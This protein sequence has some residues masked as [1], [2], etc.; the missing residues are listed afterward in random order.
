M[1]LAAATAAATAAARYSGRHAVHPLFAGTAQMVASTCTGRLTP[2]WVSRAQSLMQTWE[3]VAMCMPKYAEFLKK[4][5]RKDIKRAHV[6]MNDDAQ[7]R[8]GE[9]YLCCALRLRQEEVEAAG[10]DSA[11]LLALAE[12]V[13]NEDVEPFF[14][15]CREFVAS[16]DAALHKRLDETTIWREV[17]DSLFWHH[18]FMASVP[19]SYE[20]FQAAA[21]PPRDSWPAADDASGVDAILQVCA[22]ACEEG[23][24]ARSLAEETYQGF[25]D[26]S[27][28]PVQATFRGALIEHGIIVDDF[29]YEV[30]AK[31]GPASKA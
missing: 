30:R 10:E 18:S 28:A 5:S 29:T 7:A 23:G 16:Y 24:A 26:A 21:L 31:T 15:N 17:E 12:K 22:K 8:L 13:A 25:L 27:V 2:S 11:R 19:G 14:Q 3:K 4:T 6:F 1:A 20:R 9:F